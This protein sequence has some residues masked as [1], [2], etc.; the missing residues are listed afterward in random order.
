[1]C[2]GESLFWVAHRLEL[3][4]C[5]PGAQDSMEI[6]ERGQHSQEAHTSQRKAREGDRV[7]CELA[8]PFPLATDHNSTKA[9]SALEP[10]GNLD[11]TLLSEPRDL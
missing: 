10:T 7:S 5:I 9:G 11:R 2:K 3:T 6:M 1:M 4:V 8:G